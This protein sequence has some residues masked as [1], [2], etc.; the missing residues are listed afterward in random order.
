[1]APVSRGW[2]KIDSSVTLDDQ[3]GHRRR[4]ARQSGTIT[5]RMWAD[6]VT[7]PLVY[8]PTQSGLPRLHPY[9]RELRRRW[10]FVLHLARTGQKSQHYETTLGRLW[11]VVDPLLLAAVYYLF[12]AVVSSTGTASTRQAILAHLLWG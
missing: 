7:Y 5:R 9:L 10:P 11:V 8:E 3:T 12:R 2:R 1:M 4:V 6:D